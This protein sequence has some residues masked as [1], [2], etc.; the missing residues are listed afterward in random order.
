MEWIGV[1]NLRQMKVFPN[2]VSP[3]EFRQKRKTKSFTFNFKNV[4]NKKFCQK[5]K[6]KNF[7]QKRKQQKSFGKKHFPQNVKKKFL[8]KA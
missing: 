3:Y 7:W 6:K 8:Q 2:E 5:H 1:A 4:K